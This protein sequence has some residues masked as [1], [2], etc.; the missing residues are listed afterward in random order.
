MSGSHMRIQVCLV[1]VSSIWTQITGI[2][3]DSIVDVYVFIKFKLAYKAF[4]WYAYWT[5]ERLFVL[6]CVVPKIVAL[7]VG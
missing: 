5:T 4:D 7:F 1:R 2:R 3:F 6:W